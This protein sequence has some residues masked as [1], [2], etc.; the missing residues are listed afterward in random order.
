MCFLKQLWDIMY[1]KYQYHNYWG[2]WKYLSFKL[3]RLKPRRA[4][5]IGRLFIV[6]ADT[7]GQR[8]DQACYWIQG[9]ASITCM[10]EPVKVAGFNISPLKHKCQQILIAFKESVTLCKV[11]DAYPAIFKGVGTLSQTAV[12]RVGVEV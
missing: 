1:L 9:R 8:Q 10:R 7:D 6:K 2:V 11:L 3:L 5:E 4:E 12:L